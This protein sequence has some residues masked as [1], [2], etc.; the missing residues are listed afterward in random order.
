MK[1]AL[2]LCLA[3]WISIISLSLFWNLAKSRE[4]QTALLTET[5]RSFFQQIEIT[6]EWNA[7]HGGV[8]VPITETT[9]PN[10]YLKGP[11]RELQVDSSLTLTKINPAFMTRQ[12]ADI[13]SKYNNIQFHITSLNPIRPD[14]APSD[15]EKEALLSFEKENVKEIGRIIAKD[16]TTSFFYMAPLVTRPPCLKC[17][18]D[19]GYKEGDIRGGI[20]VTVPVNLPSVSLPLIIG[21]LL[22]GGAGLAGILFFGLKLTSVYTMVKNQAVIDALTGVPNRRNFTERILE[23]VNRHR[24]QKEPLSVLM[25]DID[26]FK[27]Y[28][29]TYGHAAGDACLLKI[30]Q[31]IRKSLRRPS[32][33]CARYGGEEFVIILPSTNATGALSVAVTIIENV[34]EVAIPHEQSPPAMRVTVSIGVATTESTD[35]LSH[36]TLIKQADMALYHAKDSGR[37][38]VK[39]FWN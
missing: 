13:A 30:A 1:R 9:L 25:C 21:H 36:E 29:D 37:N 16:S 15:Q 34:R 14:N 28:N 18:A 39:V 5:A 3:V 27:G 12:I 6:R 2:T 33:F 8:Y 35:A 31:T 20:S 7:S 19:Q 22:I 26:N 10:P 32:D 23:E 38:C 17:H 24:R 11:R 4:Q